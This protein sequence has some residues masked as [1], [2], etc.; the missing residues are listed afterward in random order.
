MAMSALSIIEAQEL[1]RLYHETDKVYQPP[2]SGIARLFE[3][4]TCVKSFPTSL[5]FAA[6]VSGLPDEDVKRIL[7]NS[8]CFTVMDDGRIDRGDTLS[9]EGGCFDGN[10]STG[11]C[12]R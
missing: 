7:E 8:R 11:K 5:R 4:L 3:Y 12:F 1:D 10:G 6:V 2:V 9:I